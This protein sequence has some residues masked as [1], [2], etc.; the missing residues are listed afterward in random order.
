MKVSCDSSMI[1][2]NSDIR[3]GQ[4]LRF[5]LIPGLSFG[6]ISK[7]SFLL[8]YYEEMSKYFHSKDFP[9]NLAFKS[10]KNSFLFIPANDFILRLIT[11]K[12]FF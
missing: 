7:L 8:I 11:F 2:L 1:W 6:I 5:S 10:A 9:K 4:L 3:I 12:Y